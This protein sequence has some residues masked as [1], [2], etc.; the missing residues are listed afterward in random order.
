MDNKNDWHYKIAKQFKKRDNP[1]DFKPSEAI[2]ISLSPIVVTVLDSKVKLVENKNLIISEW[3]KKRWDIDK[4]KALSIDIPDFLNQA[5]KYL[6]ENKDPQTVPVH[7]QSGKPCTIITITQL[8]TNAIQ[9]INSELLA[10]KLDLKINDKVIIVP[11]SQDDIFFL[12][13]KVL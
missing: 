1:K 7:S 3:F 10:L 12:I 8:L 13:D 6:N 2:V 5:N 4:T 11:S 9:V